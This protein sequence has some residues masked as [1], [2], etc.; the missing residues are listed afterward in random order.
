VTPRGGHDDGLRLGAHRTATAIWPSR[1]GRRSA[2]TGSWPVSRPLP[3]CATARCARGG[4]SCGPPGW[5]AMARFVIAQPDDQL[6]RLCAE[7]RASCERAGHPWDRRSHEA[8][9]GIGCHGTA[10]QDRSGVREHHPLPR[11]RAH[12]Q[13]PSALRRQQSGATCP[14][15]ERRDCEKLEM[16]VAA[17]AYAEVSAGSFHSALASPRRN[18]AGSGW[19]RDQLRDNDREHARTPAHLHARISG[20]STTECPVLARDH[21]ASGR[22]GVCSSG[23]SRCGVTVARLTGCDS[24]RRRRSCLQR[25]GCEPEFQRLPSPSHPLVFF[26]MRT[27]EGG[28]QYGRCPPALIGASQ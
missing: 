14:I 4:A 5:N 12:H 18:D 6:M 23:H 22:R 27:E 3:S 1:I 28:I 16:E 20:A 2:V 8:N 11:P 9:R 10:P 17:A 21:S 25:L 26:E 24:V 15:P 7:P 13:D 19:L